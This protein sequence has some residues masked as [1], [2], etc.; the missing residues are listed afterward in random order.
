MINKTFRLENVCTAV[1]TK[2]TV[3]G[4]IVV[5]GNSL[6]ELQDNFIHHNLFVLHAVRDREHRDR[7]IINDYA[8]QAAYNLC[9]VIDNP[10]LTL[11]EDDYT[12]SSY[13][14]MRVGFERKLAQ[15]YSKTGYIYDWSRVEK[16]SEIPDI[17][18][19]LSEVHSDA[20]VYDK[21]DGFDD[22]DN[23]LSELFEVYFEYQT[24]WLEKKCNNELILLQ[25]QL[26][27]YNMCCRFADGFDASAW[28]SDITTKIAEVAKVK[29]EHNF[30][31]F[32]EE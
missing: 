27:C 20:V 7:Y 5:V 31:W 22:Y 16:L 3:P 4:S 14:E 19:S 15:I 9:Y 1:D 26:A 23:L 8:V 24:E 32:K 18:N 29:E 11:I 6:S 28:L 17:L 10:T 25:R 2:T 30:E 13:S 12:R 21:A